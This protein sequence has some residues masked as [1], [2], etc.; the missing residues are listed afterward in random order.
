MLTDLKLKNVRTLL[1][2]IGQTAS[3]SYLN[4]VDLNLTSCLL[5]FRTDVLR[6][7]N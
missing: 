4:N 2:L 3:R 7:G 6:P 1:N 5:M